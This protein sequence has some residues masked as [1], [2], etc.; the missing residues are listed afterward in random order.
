MED[1]PSF[2]DKLAHGLA[3]FIFVLLW[4][5]TFYFKFNY[6]FKKALT[7]A[8][9]CS[10]VYGVLIELLQGWI[11]LNRESDYKDVL[12]NVLGMIFALFILLIINKGVLK[13][14]NTL[15]F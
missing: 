9:L 7:V 1:I 3:H 4:F 10:L 15:F 8:A 2:N 5:F 12:A 11:T 6:K 14:K 13:K